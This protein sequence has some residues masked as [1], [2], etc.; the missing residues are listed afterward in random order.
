[1]ADKLIVLGDF[2]VRVGIDH[3]AWRGVLGPHVLRSS[4]G[5]CLFLLR[6]CAEHRVILTNTFLCL[7]EQE[8][9]TWVHHR[10]RQ[11]HL[12]DYVLVRMRD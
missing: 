8:K 12:P 2:N 1:M 4:N 7:R 3:A 5:N 6:T 10:S 11:L 9:V